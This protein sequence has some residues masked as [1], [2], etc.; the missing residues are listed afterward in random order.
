MQTLVCVRDEEYSWP[1]DTAE[2]RRETEMIERRLASRP[3]EVHLRSAALL[4]EVVPQLRTARQR[5]LA[6]ELAC[7]FEQRALAQ[8]R[9]E[10]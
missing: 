8:S 2:A 10:R 5:E 3:A 4:R 7:E 1:M 9:S 6:E